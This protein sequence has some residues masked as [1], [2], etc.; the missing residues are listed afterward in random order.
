MARIETILS[1]EIPNSWK[2]AGRKWG[3]SLH[4]IMS[5]S[6][7]FPPSLARWAVETYSER[8]QTVLDP[9]SG[10][11]TL[12][13]EACLAERFGIG[14]DLAPEAYVV[15]RAKV[16]PVTL[17]DVRDW[18]LRAAREMRPDT[19]SIYDVEE[20]VRVFY[21]PSTLKQILAVREILAN[22]DDDT[23]N[24]VKA[25]MLGILH[26]SSE[27]S[28]SL[29]CSH[30]F[31][32]AP[33]YIKKYAAKHGLRRP[34]RNVLSCILRRAE[35][36]LAD[37]L[38]PR[39]GLAF[40]LDARSLPLASSSVDLIVTSPPYFNLQTYAWDNW[41]RLWFLG[42]RHE[43]VRRGLFESSSIPKY[44]MFISAALREMY[45]VLRDDRACILVVGEVFLGRRKV[46]MAELVSEQAADIG[47]EAAYIISDRIPKES[48]YLMYLERGQGVDRERVL[49]LY[50]GRPVMRSPTLPWTK[51]KAVDT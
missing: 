28:L 49:I 10:K 50:K 9:F 8:G 26:G 41:L 16:N 42:Y 3:S 15:T 27:T 12:P 11:G 34:N 40:N 2:N 22:A 46:D 7:S 35:A 5:R 14:N 43:D 30:S 44:R 13:L 6:G 47:F 1:S 38:P 25:I 33:Q 31:S 18:V 29:P 19:V 20:E 17:R 51:V 4:R 45:R 48:K 24:F 37:G 36:V 39:R 32:M 21:S 23:S